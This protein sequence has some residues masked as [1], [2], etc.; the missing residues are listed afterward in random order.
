VFGV[1]Q[2]VAAS[3]AWVRDAFLSAQA[4]APKTAAFAAEYM[5]KYAPPPATLA[6]VVLP[7]PSDIVRGAGARACPPGAA[8][9]M[10]WEM[11]ETT[12][13]DDVCYL[14]RSTDG[15]STVGVARG[16]GSAV[17]RLWFVGPAADPALRMVASDGGTGIM[18]AIRAVR[19]TPAAAACKWWFLGTDR[20]W[21]NPR[22]VLHSVRGLPHDGAPIVHGFMWKDMGF[23]NMVTSPQ[24]GTSVWSRSAWAAVAGAVGTPE[25][26]QGGLASEEIALAHCAL[27]RGVVPCD[28]HLY[29]GSGAVQRNGV[30]LEPGPPD[31]SRLEWLAAPATRAGHWAWIDNLDASW[32]AGGGRDVWAQYVGLYGPWGLAPGGATA[33]APP[34]P[35]P[36]ATAAPGLAP[37]APP[38][39]AR[40]YTAL[41]ALLDGGRASATASQALTLDAA[42]E[43]TA[44]ACGPAARAAAGDAPGGTPGG[45]RDAV[46]DHLCFAV[47][48]DSGDGAAQTR[49]MMEGGW[50]GRAARTAGHRLLWVFGGGAAAGVAAAGGEGWEALPAG[51]P[52]VAAALAAMLADPHAA[53][54]EWLFFGSATDWVS[55][56]V[57]AGALR[58]LRPDVAAAVAFW[59][60]GRGDVDEP[61]LGKVV[62]SAAALRAVA[63]LLPGC[64]GGSGAAAL[65]A[66]VWAAGVIPV[67]TYAIDVAN[68][69]PGTDCAW[70]PPGH[71]LRAAND[72]AFL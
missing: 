58:G 12:S 18:A 53:H 63:P 68:F 27:A 47:L 54:C 10:H 31:G 14:L 21:V 17:K 66:C 36:T 37:D 28:F 1:A 22:V 39:A 46:P 49:L 19:D 29:D 52:R 43:A 61:A 20:A 4:R 45:L 44:G 2:C 25:C 56:P 57:L 41:T 3:A 72:A 30:P 16:W 6:D 70:V 48:V 50:M 55:P 62:L 59:H 35:S 64:A 26:S 23:T 51:G 5:A 40:A 11:W 8:E 9:A 42:V 7:L 15:G 24:G 38:C 32:Q 13:L 65:A 67:T 71:A 69:G 33:S 60:H 34:R